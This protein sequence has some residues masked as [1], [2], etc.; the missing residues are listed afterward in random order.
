VIDRGT[1]ISTFSME[2]SKKKKPRSKKL[3]FK[4]VFAGIE[5]IN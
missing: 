4:K 3:V 1:E 2:K 5:E